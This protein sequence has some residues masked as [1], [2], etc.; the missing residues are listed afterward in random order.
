[1]TTPSGMIDHSAALPMAVL[2]QPPALLRALRAARAVIGREVGRTVARPGRILAAVLFPLFW[3]VVFSPGVQS[4]SGAVSVTPYDGAYKPLLEYVIPGLV[5]LVLLLNGV[6]SAL[7]FVHDREGE[8]VGVLMTAPLPR[9]IL[10]LSRLVA[11]A[12]VSLVEAYLFLFAAWLLGFVI[13]GIDVPWNGWAVAVPFVLLAAWMLAA[14]GLALA[15]LIRVLADRA[16]TILFLVLPVFL[17]SSALYPVWRFRDNDALYLQTIAAANPF[18]HAVELIR[19]AAYGSFTATSLAVVL[20]VGI[21]SST[22]VVARFDPERR[23]VR[24]AAG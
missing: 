14:A 7:A 16:A 22:L 9:W 4:L 13:I 20:G 8:Q 2:R 15:V 24:A 17:L 23:P 10:L 3:L 21:L 12:I 6:Q 19:Y 11:V 5:A 18:T 1:M